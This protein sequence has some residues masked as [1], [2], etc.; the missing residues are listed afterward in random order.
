M[1]VE[2]HKSWRELCNASLNANDPD[3]LMRILQELKKALKHEEQVLRDFWDAMKANRP[4]ATMVMAAT[5]VDV[6][7]VQK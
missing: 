5:R 4:R 6:S 1:A 2:E 3:E 7:H